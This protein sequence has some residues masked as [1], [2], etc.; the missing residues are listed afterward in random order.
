[1]NSW[2]WKKRPVSR[3]ACKKRRHTNSR[4]SSTKGTGPV[5]DRWRCSFAP[6]VL[7]FPPKAHHS[8]TD[9]TI[10]PTSRGRQPVQCPHMADP[11]S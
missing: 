6:I 9:K 5:D 2:S 7:L 1:M 11:G 3:W 4:R 8:K 10:W